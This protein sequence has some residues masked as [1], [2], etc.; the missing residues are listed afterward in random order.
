MLGQATRV[1]TVIIENVWIYLILT[2]GFFMCQLLE[3]ISDVDKKVRVM[4]YKEKNDVY[5]EEYS[6]S[7][8]KHSVLTKCKINVVSIWNVK[9]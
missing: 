2:G 7:I 6:D 1:P 9:T 8:F 5:E 4:W 3:K